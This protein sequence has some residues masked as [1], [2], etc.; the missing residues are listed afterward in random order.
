[1]CKVIKACW[2]ARLF[3]LRNGELRNTLEQDHDIHDQSCFQM[4]KL[5]VLNGVFSRKRRANLTKGRVIQAKAREAFIWVERSR[6]Y[7]RQR[8]RK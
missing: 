3:P 4:I 2:Q 8:D 6:E 7:A 5:K 1:M